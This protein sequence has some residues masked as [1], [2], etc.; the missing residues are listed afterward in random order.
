MTSFVERHICI[1]D[2]KIRERGAVPER[3]VLP[4]AEA[5]ALTEEGNNFL[6]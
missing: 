6:L 3:F 2:N 4:T 5:A 1:F